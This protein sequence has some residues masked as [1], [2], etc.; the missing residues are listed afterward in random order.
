MT[1]KNMYINYKFILFLLIVSIL[2]G[3]N[4]SPQKP[5]ISKNKN[6]PKL[7][8]V[9]TELENEILK[10][11]YD[12]DSTEGIKKTIEKET[13]LK[14]GKTNGMDAPSE[15]DKQEQNNMKEKD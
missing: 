5:D 4:K 8:K 3:C 6:L 7:P 11:M 14:A 15:Q 1:K 2:A 13:V 12:L 9:L 10:I